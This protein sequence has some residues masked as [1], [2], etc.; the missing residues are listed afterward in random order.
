[1]EDVMGEIAMPYFGNISEG[2]IDGRH[3]RGMS[4]GEILLGEILY[5]ICWGRWKWQTSQGEVSQGE[6]QQ[7]WLQRG[8]SGASKKGATG[9]MVLQF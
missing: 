9:V 7:K 6:G 4:R 5:S 1:M 2:D 3:C 8:S